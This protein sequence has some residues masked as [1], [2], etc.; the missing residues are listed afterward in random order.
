VDS[1]YFI[2][3]FFPKREI[4]NSKIS[5][6]KGF[7]LPKVRGGEIVKIAGFLYLIFNV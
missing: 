5:D 4:Q 7:Q 3:E 6:F 1:F 2:C